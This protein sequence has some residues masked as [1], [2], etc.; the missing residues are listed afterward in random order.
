M[1]SEA[2][3]IRQAM[4]R[5]RRELTD[6]DRERANARL[7]KNLSSVR[8]LHRCERIGLYLPFGG[9]A[10]C[11]QMLNSEKLRKKRIFLPVLAKNHLRFAELF[12]DSEMRPNRFGILEPAHTRATLLQPA[13][14]DVVVTPL[15]AFDERCNR[16]GMGA[17][18]YDRSFA[19]RT[20]RS[21][22]RKPLLIGAAYDFQRL[23]SIPAEPWD[24]ALDLVV[25]DK[26]QYGSD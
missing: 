21:K 5:A 24:V 16:I 17:G 22:W 18:F 8:A 9:E 20:R 23:P 2:H 1:N 13:E 10:D 12:S 6:A 14:L 25:T 15:V 19:F 7:N 26:K 4:K 3:A 11:L